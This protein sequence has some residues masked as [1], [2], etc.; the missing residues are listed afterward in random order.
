MSLLNNQEIR[1]L[2]NKVYFLSLLY[3][4][5][6]YEINKDILRPND[7][8]LNKVYKQI[9]TKTDLSL[10]DPH[11]LFN[12]FKSSFKPKRQLNVIETRLLPTKT[13]K[14]NFLGVPDKEEIDN[15][16]ILNIFKLKYLN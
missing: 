1:N 3:F 5:E 10:Y 13:I 15:D 11:K 12:M 2:K 14:S 16:F 9:Q 7:E 8:E 4:T 6:I